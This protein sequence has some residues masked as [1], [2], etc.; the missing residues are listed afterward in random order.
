[1]APRTTSPTAIGQT[2]EIQP[3]AS[4]VLPLQS[5]QMANDFPAAV[6]STV[7]SAQTIAPHDPHAPAASAWQ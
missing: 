4:E 1:M 7:Q 3:R 5:L 6:W 2:S